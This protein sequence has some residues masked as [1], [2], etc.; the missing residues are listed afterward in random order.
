MLQ[1]V[2][3]FMF[4]LNAC[5]NLHSR[6]LRTICRCLVEGTARMRAQSGAR[7]QTTP[8]AS[9]ELQEIRY[10]P[11]KCTPYRCG[12]IALKLRLHEMCLCGPASARALAEV[13]HRADAESN[14]RVS[15]EY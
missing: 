3:H 7:V 8:V 9:K 1:I 4:Q 2:Y 15:Q 12:D 14:P 13:R 10:W 11:N 5:S 6:R